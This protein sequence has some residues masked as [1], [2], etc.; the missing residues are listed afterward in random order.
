MTTK[1]NLRDVLYTIKQYAF[2]TS[3]Y[4]VILSIED[5]CS[6]P[7]QRIL[8]SEL[9]EILGDLLL[10]SPVSRDE[11]ELPSPNALRHK[12]ILKHKKLQLP[13]TRSG[14][15]RSSGTVRNGGDDDQN[16]NCL[17]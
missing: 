5:N 1:L 6:V 16:S 17:I 15:Y 8:A 13:E 3:D 14:S 2:E 12:I 9:R 11:I 4:P 10:T 7:A